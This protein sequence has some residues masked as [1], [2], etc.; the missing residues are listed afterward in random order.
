MVGL[1][2]TWWGHAAATVEIGGARIALDPLLTDR[3]L[4]LRRYAARP[5]ASATEADAVLIS[6]LHTDHLHLPSL[7]RFAPDVPLVV[8]RG[9]SLL[10]RR[11]GPRRLREVQPG[12]TLEIAGVRVSALPA[13]HS[14]RRG[15]HSRAA[16]PALGFRVEGAG[17]SFWYPG[18]TE[19]RPDMA[20]VASVDLAL[21]PIGGWGP[22]LAG[23]H[24][25]PA[26]AAEAVRLVGART[27]VPVHWGTFWPVGLR[28]LAP[29]N[30]RR[31]FMT[32]GERFVASLAG[33]GITPLI[34]DHGKRVVL[35]E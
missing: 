7:R 19:L 6:H 1:A 35:D 33:S 4:H 30:H 15:P 20:D 12:D 26:A 22:T 2:F 13:S 31:L 25:D 16:G 27:A 14:G 18:D 3:L 11:V 8:P 10:L 32:P 24:M 23:G 9:A 34:A 28:Y 29:A 17:R 5:S 21:V